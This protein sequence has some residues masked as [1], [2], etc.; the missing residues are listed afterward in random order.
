MDVASSG[1]LLPVGMPR[2]VLS[3][4]V[5]SEA[6]S[7]AISDLADMLAKSASML[8]GSYLDDKLQYYLACYHSYE[9]AKLE[10]GG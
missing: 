6:D 3:R 2:P 9:S 4:A 8:V 1:V 7:T 5:T 10:G